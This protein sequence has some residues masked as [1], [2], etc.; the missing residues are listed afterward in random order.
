LK[1]AVKDRF[2]KWNTNGVD[3][4]TFFTSLKINVNGRDRLIHNDY[5]Y[6]RSFSKN[7]LGPQNRVFFLGQTLVDDGY[8]KLNDYLALLAKIKEDFKDKDFIYVAHPRESTK[9]LNEITQ[10]LDVQVNRFDV[11]IEFEV[12]VRSNRP[13]IIAGFFCSALENCASIFGEELEV[14]AYRIDFKLL[15]SYHEEVKNVYAHLENTGKVNVYKAM[16]SVPV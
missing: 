7:R 9:Y 4:L 15:L 16:N 10:T 1:R 5:R 8:V 6:L 3:S 2:G 13:E 14:R 11:P 12:T